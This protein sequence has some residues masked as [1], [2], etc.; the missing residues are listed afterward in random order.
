MTTDLKPPLVWEVLEKTSHFMLRGERQNCFITHSRGPV[1]N[2]F[3]WNIGR[4]AHGEAASWEAAEEMV[5]L[6]VKDLQDRT[7]VK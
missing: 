6:A 3:F 7:G 1:P 2:L 5:A 4:H